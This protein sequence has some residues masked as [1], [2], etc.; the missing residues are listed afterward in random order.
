MKEDGQNN[1]ID[2]NKRATQLKER[3][4]STISRIDFALASIT[5]ND[6][7]FYA[8]LIAL[9]VI[10]LAI[11]IHFSFIIP[12]IREDALSYLFKAEEILQGNFTPLLER[13]IGLSIWESIFILLLGSGELLSDISI[14]KALSAI[15]GTLLFIPIA[16]I[17]K[18]L[19][20]RNVMIVSVVLFTFQPWLI[21]NAASAY[22]EPLFTL[23][24][25]T[26][27]YFL[28]KS[29]D[30]RYYLLLASGVASFSYL[31]RPNG[32]LLVPILCIYAMLMRNDIPKWK[33]RYLIYI[34]LVF[35]IVSLPYSWLRWL[36]Y[37]SPIYYGVNSDFFA[38]SAAQAGSKGQSIFQFLATHSPLYIL[39]REIIGL[40]RTIN[41][42]MSNMLIPTVGFAIIGLIYTF[43]RRCSFIHITYGIWI[44]FFSWIFYLFRPTRYF[45]PLV[46]LAI[47]LAAFTIVKISKQT[48][49]KSLTVFIIL[50]YLVGMSGM[51]LVSSHKSLQKTAEIWGDGMEWARWISTNIEPDQSIAIREGGDLIR[52][53]T[54]NIELKPIPLCDNLSTTMKALQA[55]D[56]NYLVIG[57]GGGETP[58]WEKRPVL[59]EVYFGEYRPEYMELVYSNRDSDSNWKM[60]IYRID[61]SK[62]N[63]WNGHRK[64][65]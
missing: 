9:F 55:E 42:A 32:I 37:G 23:I 26:T 40:A 46:P 21:T 58:D 24:L 41:A 22:T 48:K 14:A 5:H 31:V 2:L 35:I 50:I 34:V 20:N 61:W 25:L 4:S 12:I 43:K 44:L 13:G 38:E 16:L 33:N 18:K 29:T 28:L 60:Q 51:E 49:F 53:H 1:A 54:S 3:I 7:I 63:H 8:F 6:K 47:I 64:P 62:F 56:T 17:S 39:K 59:K 52:L 15:T 36:E 57:D 10:A 45:I 11:R 27:F 65:G 30:H 19:F